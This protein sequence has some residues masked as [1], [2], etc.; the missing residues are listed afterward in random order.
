MTTA[1][2]LAAVTRVLQGLLKEKLDEQDLAAAL[3]DVEDVRVTALAPDLVDADPTDAQLNLFLYA[4]RPDGAWRN[5]E[6]PARGPRGDRQRD[7]PLALDL[8]Y[9]L[10]AYA[11]GPLHAEV[12]LGHAALALHETPVL[13]SK[14]I[15]QALTVDDADEDAGLLSLLAA[16]ELDDQVESVRVTHSELTTDELFRLWSAFD[17][18]YRPTVGYT[19]R[20]VLLESRGET[21]AS[22]P[23]QRWD[24]TVRPLRQPRLDRVRHAESPTAPITAGVTV[25]LEGSGLA[26]ERTVVRFGW[27][28]VAVDPVSDERVEVTLPM[29]LRA[30]VVGVQV[31]HRIELGDPA[32]ERRFAESNVVAF[33]LRP[34]I[35][36]QPNWQ[37]EELTVSVSPP[38]GGDQRVVVLLNEAV[39]DPAADA[40][41]RSYRLALPGRESSESDFVV[42]VS[43]VEAATYLVR[44]QV[45]GAE[46]PLEADATGELHPRVGP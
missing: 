18:A 20:V 32:E 4:I 6:L 46:S 22:L 8:S 13:S 36:G 3:A 38:V 17:G 23:V 19:A 25:W 26:G 44:V 7:A 43:D 30:G 45:D 9:L 27:E 2:G 21:S 11:G 12:L 42:D 37:G 34:T 28:E 1:F 5:T 40:P 24:L 39:D 41:G 31:A 29:A 10:T 16:S 15:R 33:V 14:R 35:I